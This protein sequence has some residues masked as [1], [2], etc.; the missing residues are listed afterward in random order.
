MVAIASRARA[1]PTLAAA[2]AAL[3]AASL[4]SPS[5]S[6]GV[7]PSGCPVGVREHADDG[8]RVAARWQRHEAGD[9][10][11]VEIAAPDA[12][13]P[14]RPPLSV[15]IVIDRSKSMS[16]EPIEH[17]KAAAARLVSR[18]DAGDAF[19]V[20]AYS[21]NDT[22]VV[23]MLPASAAHKALAL[24]AIAEL[25]IDNGTC[26]SCGLSRA[27][28]WLGRTPIEG[29][30]RRMVL[31][32]DG[33]ANLGLRDRDDLV[34]LAAGA[35][36]RGV[37]ITA[38][39]VGEDFDEQTMMR[40]AEVGRG[41][42]Y[43]VADAARLD[44]AFAREIERLGET[45]ATDVRL[46]VQAPGVQPG[47]QIEQALGHAMTAAGGAVAIPI[48]DLR[49]GDTRKVVLRVTGAPPP[50]G[51]VASL[52]WR[53]S[54][55]GAGRGALAVARIDG[56]GG[57]STAAIEQALAGA[58]LERAAARDGGS[59]GAAEARRVL[60][61]YT[62][63]LD[64]RPGLDPVVRGEL[65]ARLD[66]AAAAFGTAAG[67]GDGAGAVKLARSLAHALAR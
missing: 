51:L 16:G 64:R 63:A 32:S 29:G 41:N 48:S 37:S 17:A 27:A 21:D 19:T 40:I 44:A 33:Y 15:A 1:L 39:G 31:I 53:R 22:T 13:P 28:E 58:V 10:V 14:V 7:P 45:V 5:P 20:I 62:A 49:A 55:D 6:P 30:I 54:I 4:L 23:P 34:A 57:A 18:L 50:C 47:V 11:V 26:I 2:G 8:M 3:I 52:S 24:R 59:R 42:Y 65:R 60:E 43:Y 56:A 38:V 61:A 12:G 46:T 67:G 36:A 9:H 35:A 25:E 66:E